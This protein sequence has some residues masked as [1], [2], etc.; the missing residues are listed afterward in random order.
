MDKKNSLPILNGV[1]LTG[2]AMAI[3]AYVLTDYGANFLWQITVF[4][5]A[6]Y[7]AVI[8]GA[9]G[10]AITKYDFNF[11]RGAIFGLIFNAVVGFI[12]LTFLGHNVVIEFYYTYYASIIIGALNGAIISLVNR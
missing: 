6:V 2:I 1:S 10:V 4:I 7:G 11:I 9:A 3:V 12:L 5:F 8:G